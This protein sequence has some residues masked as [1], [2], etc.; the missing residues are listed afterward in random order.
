MRLVN[1]GNTGIGSN[2]RATFVEGSAVH[3]LTA[4]YKLLTELFGEGVVLS[5]R[6]DYRRRRC[7]A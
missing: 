4:L 3:D 2:E 6:C 1:E 7:T 5:E